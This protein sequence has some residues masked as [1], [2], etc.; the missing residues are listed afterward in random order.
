VSATV[1]ASDGT[2]ADEA[3]RS[4]KISGSVLADRMRSLHQRTQRTGEIIATVQ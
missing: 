3:N 2:A 1:I 4:G